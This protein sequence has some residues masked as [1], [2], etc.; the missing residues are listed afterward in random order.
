LSPWKALGRHVQSGDAKLRLLSS[1]PLFEGVG[2]SHLRQLSSQLDEVEF[3]RDQVL[4][5]QGS[6][7]RALYLLIEGEVD[8]DDESRQ[9]QTLGAGRWFGERSMVSSGPAAVTAVAKTA[10]RA[11]VMSRS[12]FRAL[13]SCPA[14][15]RR[16][17]GGAAG[18]RAEPAGSSAEFVA[19]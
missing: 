14:L 11:L 7:D 5:R 4:M 3:A 9:S 2:S 10:G 17:V 6:Y 8:V 18:G 19:N 12:Q 16:L 15:M 1:L 13:K